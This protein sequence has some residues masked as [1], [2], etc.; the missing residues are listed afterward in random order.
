MFIERTAQH[1]FE[2]PLFVCIDAGKT[3]VNWY[4]STSQAFILFL[5]MKSVGVMG[6]GR[7]NEYVVPYA[8]CR[9]STS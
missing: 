6:D 1:L 2:L 4:E 8:R 9:R 5:P 3:P 7:T